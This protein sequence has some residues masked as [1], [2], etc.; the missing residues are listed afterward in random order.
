MI[1]EISAPDAAM[2]K[3]LAALHE[4][5]FAPQVRGWKAT[6]I[7]ALADEG[8]LFVSSHGFMLI[9][10][11]LD[12]AEVLTVAVDP[13]AQGTGQGRQLLAHALSAYPRST[14][15]LEVAADNALALAL[16]A[17]SGFEEVGRRRGYYER[18]NGQSTDALTMRRLPVLE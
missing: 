1:R 10:T 9:R 3:R 18:A 2:L 13:V 15:F 14:F 4:R 17:S 5:A 16:Y 8:D 11:V 7:A 12:E 6:E